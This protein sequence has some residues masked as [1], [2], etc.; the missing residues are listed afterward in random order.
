MSEDQYDD[1]AVA[2]NPAYAADV[3][4]AAAEAAA[5]ELDGRQADIDMQPIQGRRYGPG[6]NRRATA[7]TSVI[8]ITLPLHP[9]W[10]LRGPPTTDRTGRLSQP[11]GWDCTPN[12]TEAQATAFKKLR[13]KIQ[14]D[15]TAATA[16][17]VAKA[18]RLAISASGSCRSSCTTSTGGASTS[19][20][21]IPGMAWAGRTPCLGVTT[22]SFAPSAEVRRAAMRSNG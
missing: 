13:R 12:L 20:P 17:E 15:L 18:V 22:L 8:P 21:G 4:A 5:F 6:C 9:V 16:R 3:A 19:R 10:P 1:D 11:I 14:S 7:A 2:A